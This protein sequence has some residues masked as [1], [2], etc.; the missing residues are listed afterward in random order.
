[1]GRVEVKQRVGEQLGGEPEPKDLLHTVQSSDRK[2]RQ[3]KSGV[4]RTVTSEKEACNEVQEKHPSWVFGR[5][6]SNKH[7]HGT[8]S[9]PA[10]RDFKE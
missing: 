2:D 4:G 9:F 5:P 3:R 6:V 7:R 1:M 10:E 8:V